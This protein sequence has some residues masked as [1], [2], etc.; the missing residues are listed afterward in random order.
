MARQ[1]AA[2]G[3]R[4][5]FGPLLALVF[6]D[7][8][9]VC[10]EALNTVSRIPVCNGCLREP[11]PQH[12]EYACSTC[13]MPFVNSF[14]LDEAGRCSL[15][16]LG[17]L[18]FGA[19]YTYGSYEG[20]LRTLVHLLKFERIHTLARPLSAL[21][22]RVLP[23]EQRFDF[24]VPVPLHWRRRRQRGFNQAEL[25]A[26]EIA[27]RWNAPVAHALRRTR[28]TAPQSGLTNAKRR[29]NLRGAFV[30]ASKFAKGALRGARVLLVD[31]VI[32]T[33]ASA[34]ACAAVLKRA[35][36]AHVA[37]AAVA[38]TDRRLALPEFVLSPALST[39][40]AGGNS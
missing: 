26:K 18:N 14:P 16:R 28:A 23:R 4:G 8:C 32:T 27:R 35:G 19:V 24:I 12:A 17:L 31:D 22:L 33:G 2:K 25:L 5:L 3:I 11:Q 29:A 21:M 34:A 36:A 20:T 7:D 37:V 13:R 40:G 10:G 9:R 30:P 15:C 39:A 6:P 1:V 38:R